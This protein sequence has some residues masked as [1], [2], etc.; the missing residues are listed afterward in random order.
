MNADLEKEMKNSIEF[1]K[2]IACE[3][4]KERYRDELNKNLDL[5]SSLLEVKDF[6]GANLSPDSIC[7]LGAVLWTSIKSIKA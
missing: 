6:T 2:I 1:I 4:D 7:I 5:P 3:D